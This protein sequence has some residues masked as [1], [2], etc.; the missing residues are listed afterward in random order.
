MADTF[1]YMFGLK[2]IDELFDK[3]FSNP[4]VSMVN[5]IMARFGIFVY[6]TLV[7][8]IMIWRQ[9]PFRDELVGL[10]RDART[11]VNDFTT[12]MFE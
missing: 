3:I 9:K 11:R 6:G 4:D 2:I 1:R 7:P 8:F 12:S 5:G 10:F